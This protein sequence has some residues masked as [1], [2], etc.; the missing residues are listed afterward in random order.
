MEYKCRLEKLDKIT[1]KDSKDLSLCSVCH[2][3]DCSNPIQNVQISMFGVNT[4][5]RAYV[6][7]TNYFGVKQCEG[8]SSRQSVD[9][10]EKDQDED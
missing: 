9:I 1:T 7:N 5:I 8:F 3:C 4:T 10:D 2:S 6:T